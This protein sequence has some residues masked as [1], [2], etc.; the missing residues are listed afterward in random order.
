[1]LIAATVADRSRFLKELS[2]KTPL[3]WLRFDI[4][5]PGKLQKIEISQGKVLP[6]RVGYCLE[7]RIIIA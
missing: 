7:G 5:L 4:E 3:E 1:L 6:A 2:T